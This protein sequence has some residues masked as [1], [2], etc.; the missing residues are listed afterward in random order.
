MELI[1][2]EQTMEQAEKFFDGRCFDEFSEH[3]FGELVDSTKVILNTEDDEFTCLIMAAIRYCL[4]RRTYMPSYITGYIKPLLPYV[5]DKLLYLLERDIR[6][7]GKYGD[8]AYGDPLI[9]KPTW[10]GFY[11]NVTSEIALKKA[12]GVWAYD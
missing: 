6:E 2:R 8:D 11:E 4:G 12:K 9:D 7:Q 3:D 1:S 5:S 10:M